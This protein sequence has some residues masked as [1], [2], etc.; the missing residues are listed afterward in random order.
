MDDSLMIFI[1]KLVRVS[2]TI[3]LVGVVL[4]DG[5]RV[6]AAFSDAAGGLK[7]ASNAVTDV[8]SAT[9]DDVAGAQAAAAAAATARGAELTAYEQTAA[10][11]AAVKVVDVK[12]AV[13]SRAKKTI[14]V[15]AVVGLVRRTPASEWYSGAGAQ[16]TLRRSKR[17]NVY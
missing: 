4:N 17:V 7:D 6:I 13:S 14:V 11:G 8:V 2:L 16:I 10:L 3:L 12:L 1:A 9:P 5:I 15:A